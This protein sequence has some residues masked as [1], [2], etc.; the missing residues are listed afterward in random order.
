MEA[1][2]VGEEQRNAWEEFVLECPRSIAWQSY[3][4]SKVLRKNYDLDF[5]PIA[6][7][8]GG[9][10]HGVLPLYRMKGGLLSKE[11]LISV[12]FA[13]AGG[14]A[15]ESEDAARLLFEKAV[16]FSGNTT[17][18]GITLKHYKHSFNAG[19]RTDDNY[20]NRELRLSSGSQTIL[21]ALDQENRTRIE[22][23]E[24]YGLKLEFPSDDISGFCRLLFR[25]NHMMG[26]P[27]VSSR[28]IRDLIDFGMYSLAL[29]KIGTTIF[30]GTLVKEFKDTV[31]F[32]FTSIP[33]LSPQSTAAAYGLYWKLIE[34]FSEEG[35]EIFHS[36]RIPETG[37]VP[38]FRL[39][40]GG[41]KYKYFYQYWP[42]T[43]TRTEYSSK[44]GSKRKLLENFWKKM[45]AVMARAIG[46]NIVER[47][48]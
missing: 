42:P 39:G 4:W 37:G 8:E 1:I 43:E 3:D 23:A 33:D 45:P 9:R 2:V 44:R 46:P 34:R 16:S 35:K 31:S 48:P 10:I 7:V 26:I 6:A 24:N 19:L 36:G 47:F 25:Y 38:A 21:G 22:E 28:W 41:I 29:A 18:P 20:Y 12:P 15:C 32:P 13:V 14:I 40:W 11:K 30:A 5:Y 17:G 27:C